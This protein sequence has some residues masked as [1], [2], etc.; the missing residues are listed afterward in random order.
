MKN[1]KLLTITSFWII[2]L[3]GINACK[4]TN[5]ANENEN[6]VISNTDIKIEISQPKSL[7]S[8][9][10][11]PTSIIEI[12]TMKII[13]FIN[14]VKKQKIPYY[15]STNFDNVMT[16][17][18]LTD[19]FIHFLALKQIFP[20]EMTRVESIWIRNKITL[21]DTF[22][23]LIFGFYLNEHE[24][25]TTL[26]TY[27]KGFNLIDY[28]RIAYD[29]IAESCNRTESYFDINQINVFNLIF[30]NEMQNDTVNFIV[31]NTGKISKKP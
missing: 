16:T 3:L 29:E 4:E 2:I 7:N 24:L 19:D 21:S 18:F 26:V 27:T 9:I 28:Q 20:Y 8:A 23:S 14:Q 13:N 10:S 11:K 15:D 17:E 12:D 25:Y 30:C 31:T 22:I 1:I 5:K 6:E